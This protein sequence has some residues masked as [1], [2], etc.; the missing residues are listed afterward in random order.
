M[1][2]IFTL[3]F[4]NILAPVVIV[5][6]IYN[7]QLSAQEYNVY[8]GNI[9]SHSSYS[10]GNQDSTN[11]IP[12]DDY[13]YAS[14]S[15][16]FDFLG[17]S[18]HNHMNTSANFYNGTLQADSFNLTHP[19][20][21]ALYGMEWGYYSYG[22]VVIYESQAL[23]GWSGSYDVYTDAYDYDSLFHKIV[24]KPGC[25]AYLAHPSTAHFGGLVS[26]PFDSID[27]KAIIGMAY[28]ATSAY[29]EDTTYSEWPG[30]YPGYFKKMLLRGY[31]PGAGIDH[32]NH[33]TNYGRNTQSRLAVLALY[34]EKYH[35]LD[36]LRNR[37][38]FA[39]EDWN[40]VINFKIN[41]QPMGSIFTSAGVPHIE[42]YASD[43]DGET[44]SAI[45]LYYG[46]KGDTVNTYTYTTV[47]NTDT[48]TIDTDSIPDLSTHFYWVVV[49]Q[50]D[51][52]II[53]SSP[54]WYTRDDG[55]LVVGLDEN[56]APAQAQVFPNPASAYFT[57]SAS[58]AIQDIELYNITGIMLAKHNYSGNGFSASF[59][60]TGISNGICIARIRTT[61]GVFTKKII[62]QK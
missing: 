61:S 39:T 15:H 46:I 47:Y 58:S 59:P 3:I 21:V 32:D 62:V 34:R 12:Y 16:H 22:H 19:N 27:D 51:G 9:H 40:A 44:A 1:K 26:K 52:D 18:D 53:T 24:A 49:Q 4:K 10:D 31:H 6:S 11:Y 50:D 36:A 33:K 25:F 2:T 17:I 28:G 23:Y 7:G 37:R 42:V 45:T 8:Y 14:Q 54:I 30:Y 29:S 55:Q 48:L 41:L 38:F 43:G 57:V 13:V 20:F 5:L 56:S 35:I 60:L